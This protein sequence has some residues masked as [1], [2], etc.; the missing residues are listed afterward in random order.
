LLDTLYKLI[1]AN[2]TIKLFGAREIRVCWLNKFS[3]LS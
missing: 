1:Y 2:V 3:P